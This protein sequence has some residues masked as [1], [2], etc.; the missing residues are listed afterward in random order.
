MTQRVRD[1]GGYLVEYVFWLINSMNS[2]DQ[3]LMLITDSSDRPKNQR[4][5]L[6]TD[7]SDKPK[8]QF[9]KLY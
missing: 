9:Q 7:S 6:I 8:N 4:L 5:M 3:R 1:G 2:I